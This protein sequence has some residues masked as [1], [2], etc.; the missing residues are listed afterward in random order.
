[1]VI[2][3]TAHLT[4]EGAAMYLPATSREYVRVPI[5]A[6]AGTDVT[7]LPVGIALVAEGT[8]P[9]DGDYHTGSWIDGEAALLI[10][11]GDGAVTY[12]PGAYMLWWRLTSGAEQISEPA[13]RIRIGD[14]RF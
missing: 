11:P 14:V 7:T 5:T 10:G 6:P 13:G 9:A 2:R 4:K 3:R 8:E 12:P 1:V